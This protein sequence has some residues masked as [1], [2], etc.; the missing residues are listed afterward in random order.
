MHDSVPG[1]PNP[2][3]APKDNDDEFSVN[4]SEAQLV[5]VILSRMVII[6]PSWW[7]FGRDSARMEILSGSG[8]SPS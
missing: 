6:L 5:V 3:G 8:R 7:T 1:M 2:F 4:L